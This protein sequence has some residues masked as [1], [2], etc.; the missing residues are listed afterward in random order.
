MQTVNKF[1]TIDI[2]FVQTALNQANACVYSMY[3]VDTSK[4][5]LATFRVILELNPFGILIRG[6]IMTGKPIA[7]F[8]IP[9]KIL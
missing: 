9:I 8:K 1:I 3:W 4:P 6:A 5:I 7:S 2:I